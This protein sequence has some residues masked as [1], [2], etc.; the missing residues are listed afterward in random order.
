M[1]PTPQQK[2]AAPADTTN[3]YEPCKECKK[4]RTLCIR[5]RRAI[6]KDFGHAALSVHEEG[7]KPVTYANWPSKGTGND[8]RKN[9]P[10]DDY[11]ADPR[12][13]ATDVKCKELS[14]EEE[15][16]LKEELAKPQTY[17]LTDNNCAKWSGSTWNSVTGGS[18]D[19]GAGNTFYSSPTTLADS[20]AQ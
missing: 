11:N 16:K 12:W 5:V 13:K 15:K 18:L 1:G 9:D 19:Y 10:G 2:K 7:Q 8:L 4:K 14:E 6:W 20:M 17:G 3:L